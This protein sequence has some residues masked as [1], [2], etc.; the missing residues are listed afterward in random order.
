[1]FHAPF[2]VRLEAQDATLEPDVFVVCDHSKLDGKICNG[3]PDLVIEILSP[4][5]AGKD[6]IVKYQKYLQAGVRE[7]W[8][9]DLETKTLYVNLLGDGEYK[10]QV[11]AKADTVPVHILDGCSIRLAEVFAE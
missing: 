8:I 5:T 6:C 11:Y 7:Y 9:V 1:L 10:T 2:T 3:A 4:S